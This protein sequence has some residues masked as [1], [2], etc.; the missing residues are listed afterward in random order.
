MIVIL[1]KKALFTRWLLIG[2]LF[3]LSI[4]GLNLAAVQVSPQKPRQY[5]EKRGE[6]VW[7]LAMPHK[8]VAITFDDGPSPSF[9]RQ[10][11]DL[12]SHYQGYA[13][14]FVTGTQVEKFP[15]VLQEIARRRHEIGNHLY[16][17]RPIPSLS[18]YHL[19]RELQ[20]THRLVQEL[21]GNTI[22]IFR[23]I[24]GFYDEKVVRAA[25]AM[26]YQVIIWSQ[27]SQDWSKKTGNEIATRI[28]DE[29]RP[30][31]IL[32][33][34]DQGGNRNNTIDALKIILPELASRG[35]HLITV[36]QLIKLSHH[37]PTTPV[38]KKQ[39]DSRDPKRR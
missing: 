32:L 5:F 28:I 1:I 34:H 38:L 2:T 21:T 24:N 23:P 17:H 37:P 7:E 16:H 36:S 8:A 9:T 26:N 4:G 3:S 15:D 27:D 35:Y 30:G 25:H 6:I 33:F 31:Q 14:F 12:F 39:A 13:T 20:R 22:R 11:M 29:I 19:I 10:I 18:E